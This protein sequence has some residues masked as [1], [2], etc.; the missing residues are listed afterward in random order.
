M[1]GCSHK[2]KAMLRRA[3]SENN[4]SKNNRNE[5]MSTSIGNTEL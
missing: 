4:I 2:K 1:E 3:A 5:M